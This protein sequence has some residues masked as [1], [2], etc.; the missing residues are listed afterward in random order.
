MSHLSVENDGAERGVKI[1]YDFLEF[2]KNEG[3][4]QNVLQVVEN[5]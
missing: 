3:N 2:L 1:C 4:V 5:Y